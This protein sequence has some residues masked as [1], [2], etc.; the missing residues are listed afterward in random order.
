MSDINIACSWWGI[1]S[2]ANFRSAALNSELASGVV[3]HP[4][5]SRI[6]NNTRKIFFI[7]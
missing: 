2:S 6:E 7:S 1:I 5:K 3:A 4:V